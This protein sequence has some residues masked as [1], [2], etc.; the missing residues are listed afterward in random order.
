MK[1]AHSTD[2]QRGITFPQTYREHISNVYRDGQKFIKDCLVKSKLS[3]KS[4][5][6]IDVVSL[7]SMYHDLGKLDDNAQAILSGDYSDE[8]ETKMLNHVDAG[9]A[10]LLDKYNK[11]KNLAYL[12]AASLIHA[13]HVGLN[14]WELLVKED[15]D[16]Q[17]KRVVYIY[18]VNKK[19][20][21]D[22][23]NILETYGISSPEISVS[24]Y[25]NNRIDEYENIHNNE[26]GITYNL[27]TNYTDKV[28]VSALQIRMAFSCL[29]D[30][31][32]T[33]T[34]TFYS[35]NYTPYT[36]S[37]LL[38]DNRLEK[39]KKYIDTLT[40]QPQINVSDERL[41]SRREL[42][43]ICNE[44]EIPSDISFFCLDGSVGLGKTLSGAVYQL[45]LAIQRNH[46][47]LY[48]IIPYTNIIS[49]T[50]ET[51]RKSLLINGE[52]KNNVNEIHSKCEFDEIWMRK[53][54]N[55]WKAPINVSTMVQFSESLVNNRPS[56]CRKLHWFANS[57][58]FF[59]EFDKSMPHEYWSYFLTLLQDLSDNFN[60]CFIFSSGT[61]VYY[62]DLFNNDDIIVHNIIEKE[63]YMSLQKLENKRVK[64]ETLKN[65]LNH[66]RH[67]FDI[68]NKNTGNGLIVSN[69]IKNA[70]LLAHMARDRFSDYTIYELT[71]WQT[72]SH[73]EE[74][75]KDI[76]NNL[77]KENVMVFATSTIEC[78]VDISFDFGFREKCS[79]LNILQFG[80]RINRGSVRDY[81]SVYVYEWDK[82]LT[83]KDGIFTRNPK[84][85]CGI[86]VFDTISDDNM[87]PDYCSEIVR[88][89]MELRPSDIGNKFQ[90]MEYTKKYKTISETFSVIDVNT[91]VV[92]V[93]E[94]I[95][96]KMKR[97]DKVSYSDIVRNSVQLWYNKIEKIQDLVNLDIL[98]DLNNREYYYWTR[99]YDKESGIGKI[100]LEID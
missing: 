33:D 41:K 89:E 48:N 46:Q 74:I 80:G 18:K 21:R 73:K 82:S 93:D 32:H 51:F 3:D 24:D 8:H 34:D 22:N 53:Y 83:G 42:Y 85:I 2:K 44:S 47:R 19:V 67:L 4:N 26:V 98:K 88:L 90:Q 81:A 23:R 14:N 9:V 5:F 50:T 66:P 100:M 35:S 59:D 78:G 75:L 29:V 30:A 40:N 63:P 57:V 71:G 62:W 69:T 56:R 70:S 96:N 79:L 39:L 97:G 20:F 65:L 37:D 91:A 54:S 72:P 7:A 45:R 60:C 76:K 87:S 6:L 15:I 58:F 36:F 13:H 99:E 17:S 31:D 1:L 68:I 16:K 25:I 38:P 28:P 61:S 12:I 52:D 43:N 92:I 64:I 86:E 77:V 11:S 55:L 84:I 49:Q 27:L 10:L 94:N 95:I